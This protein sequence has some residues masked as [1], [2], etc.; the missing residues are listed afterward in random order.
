MYGLE[1]FQGMSGFYTFASAGMNV[2]MRVDGSVRLMD[3]TEMKRPMNFGVFV[4]IIFFILL[5]AVG[6]KHRNTT[7]LYWGNRG[8]HLLLRLLVVGILV[9]IVALYVWWANRRDFK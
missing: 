6:W 4:S 7:P 8:D 1:Q 2:T 9:V 5:V 3:N